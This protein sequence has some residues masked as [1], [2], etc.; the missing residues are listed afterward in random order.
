MC[1]ERCTEELS[2]QRSG[3]DQLSL[4]CLSGLNLSFIFIYK[5]GC[6]PFKYSSFASWLTVKHFLQG[7]GETLQEDGVAHHGSSVPAQLTPE[8]PMA[9]PA[10]SPCPVST[11]G[12][13]SP[14]QAAS[15]A[16]SSYSALWLAA[17]ISQQLPLAFPL[18]LFCSRV[19]LV[20]HFSRTAFSSILQNR[21][22]ASSRKQISSKFHQGCT[23]AVSLPFSELWLCSNKVCITP[24]V[25]LPL[26]VFYLSPRS[27]G[28]SLFLPFLYSFEC[29]LLSTS[30]SLH[31]IRVIAND[32]FQ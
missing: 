18:G 7:A 14:A 13:A 21:F 2:K 24:L 3:L 28:C 26:Q 10:P 16:S 5:N 8:V 31:Q 29:Y 20:R 9:L 15:S 22:L 17:P 32:S 1:V 30:Q 4:Y 12:V 11:V 23:M 25:G 27:S 19:L 6:G